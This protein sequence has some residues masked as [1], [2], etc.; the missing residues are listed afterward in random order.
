MV[1]VNP[2]GKK[3]G[4][5]FVT[6]SFIYDKGVKK[7]LCICDCGNKIY[8]VAAH[9]NNGNTKSCGCLSR[10]LSSKRSYKHGGKAH[11]ERLYSIWKNMNARCNASEDHNP[12]CYKY[13]T[14]KGI[15]VCDAWRDYSSFR[16][17]AYLN[18]YNDEKTLDRINGEGDY[19]PE[20][21]RWCSRVQ[22]Q[23]NISSNKRYDVN[24]EL[25]TKREIAEKYNLTY[26]AVSGRLKRGW[27]IEKIINTP[28][29]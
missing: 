1:R 20:N 8:V 19:C 29:M 13:Y 16:D 10:E 22:Q 23:N 3:Y 27:T 15:K 6:D 11:K 26:D 14:S 25:L 9:L 2:V 17:W 5:L 18:G 4:R 7:W 24:G 12:I 28:L 21:C